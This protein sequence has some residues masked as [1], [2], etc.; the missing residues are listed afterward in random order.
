MRLLLDV[1]FGTERYPE[2]VARYERSEQLLANI[3]PRGTRKILP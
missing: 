3:L 2:K 1:R